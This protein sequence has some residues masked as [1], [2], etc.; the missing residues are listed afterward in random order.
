[1]AERRVVGA[2]A[3]TWLAGN[4]ASFGRFDTAIVDEAAQMTLPAT[5]GALRLARK[6]ILI[7]DHKQL[8]PVEDDSLYGIVETDP[9]LEELVNTSLFEMAWDGGLPEEARCLLTIQHRM[10]P[11]IA[12]YV[13]RASYE[14][15]LEDAPEVQAYEFV[16]RKPLPV[17]RWTRS[18]LSD[19]G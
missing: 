7:G 19:R 4:W 15:Q 6:F 12:A 18:S 2:T 1:M 10:H 14:G 3:V 5:L 17:A 11:Q 8:P 13:S 9:F 16:T